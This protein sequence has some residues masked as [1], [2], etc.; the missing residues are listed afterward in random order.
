[1]VKWRYIYYGCFLISYDKLSYI[2]VNITIMKILSSWGLKDLI[3]F[4]VI[5]DEFILYSDLLFLWL[6]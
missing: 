2:Y 5:F 4:Y 3:L 1:M 6:E